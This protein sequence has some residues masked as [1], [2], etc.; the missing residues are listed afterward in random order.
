MAPS[1]A[2]STMNPGNSNTAYTLSL[3]SEYTHSLDSLPLD[4]SRNFADLRELDAVL[5]SSVASITGKIQKLTRMIE[6]N[7]SPKQERLFLLAEIAEE[8]TRL[9]LGG[10]DKIRVASQAADN[11]KGHTGHMTALLSH[12]P[13]L[14]MSI[15]NRKT[16]YPHV[17]PRSF[18]PHTTMESGRRRRGAYSS[19]LA[20]APDFS[21]AKRKRQPRDDDLDGG[22]SKS[23][24]KDRSGD[25]TTQ[26]ARNGARARKPERAISPAESMVSVISHNVTQ[27]TQTAANNSRSGAQHASGRAGNASGTNKRTRPSASNHQDNDTPSEATSAARRDI[28]NA[29][30]SSS[31]SHPSLPLRGVNVYDLPSGHAIPPSEWAGPLPPGQLEGPGT[32]VVAAAA[33]DALTEAG[34]GDGEGDDRTYCFCDGISYGEMIA[35]DDASCEREWFHLACIGLSVPPDGTWY[36]EVCR[37]KQ[38]NAKRGGRGGKRRSGGARSGAKAANGA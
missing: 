27:N 6:E 35:C 26:R 31:V 16:T 25:A 18:M 30:P 15:L 13:A 22:G 8:A 34:D 10:E 36:C 23:P 7:T 12:I 9:K 38:R 21:P 1:R 28:F 11:L 33:A 20:S 2:P 19:L 5:S 37:N 24:R 17:A 14:D 32:P 3:L 29:P 4:L